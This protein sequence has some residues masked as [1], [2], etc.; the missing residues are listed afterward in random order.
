MQSLVSVCHNEQ[1]GYAE[2]WPHPGIAQAS[3][4]PSSVCTAFLSCSRDSNS[5]TNHSA[6]RTQR[7][8][9]L[10]PCRAEPALA[11]EQQQQAPSSSLSASCI[12]L[13]LTRLPRMFPNAYFD[14]PSGLSI[15]Q[16]TNKILH[17][18]QDAKIQKSPVRANHT[19]TKT[20]TM[21]TL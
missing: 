21:K 7:E 4:A 6:S 11:A 20:K 17:N 8:S 15:R 12:L 1:S 13:T 9:L 5:V 14:T 3:L 16:K 2:D 19:G 18:V 10:A